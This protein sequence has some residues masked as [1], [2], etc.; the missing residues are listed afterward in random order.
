M[1]LGT[2]TA[3]FVTNEDLVSKVIREASDGEYSHVDLVLPTKGLLGARHDGGVALRPPNYNTW[4]KVSRVQVEVPDVEAAY[5][6]AMAQLGKPYNLDAILSMVTHRDR[7]FS[8][9]QKSWFCDE[10]L[11]ATVMSGGV[12][13]LNTDNP[14]GLTPW[15]V[16]LSPFWKL[17][18]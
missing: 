14:L 2:I 16:Y 8:L 12:K 1:S 4:T 3:Q 10:L 7:S 13:L 11:Y 15:E 6:F 5:V 9:E 18:Q 17:A